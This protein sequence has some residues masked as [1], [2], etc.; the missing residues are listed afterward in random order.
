MDWVV[1]LE[2]KKERVGMAGRFFNSSWKRWLQPGLVQCQWKWE[3]GCERYFEISAIGR[4]TWLS[5]DTEQAKEVSKMMFW[6]LTWEHGLGTC[7]LFETENVRGQTKY[8]HYVRSLPFPSLLF[9]L[10]YPSLF[11]SLSPFMPAPSPSS[12]PSPSLQTLNL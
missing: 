12:H 2:I 3:I 10:S 1:L 4:G 7:C 9:L 5:G 8:N 11:P 6:F